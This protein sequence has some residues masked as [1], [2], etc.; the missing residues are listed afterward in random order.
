MNAFDLAGVS[1]PRPLTRWLPPVGG[2]LAA[3]AVALLACRLPTLHTVS[4]GELIGSAITCVLGVLL[5]SAITVWGICFLSR[6]SIAFDT[7]RLVLR[8]SLIALWIAPLALLIREK[9]P[10]AIVI[11]AVLVANFVRLV[12]FPQ[13]IGRSAVEEFSPQESNP[14]KS[15]NFDPNRN[16]FR[17]LESAPSVRQQAF[18][19]SAALCAE[20]GIA[21]AFAG[22]PFTSV[23]LVA[24]ATAVWTW[25]YAR[26][27]LPA[28]A[29]PYSSSRSSSRPLSQPLMIIALAIV[30]TAAALLPY[31]PQSF[32]G[33]FGVPSRS[34]ARRRSPQGEPGGQRSRER[35][36]EASMG[37]TTQ[38]DPG[39]VL[40]PDKLTHT[41]LVAPAPITANA[42][43]TG[44]PSADPLVIPFAGVYW[45]FRAP[46]V[47]PPRSSRQAHG[48]PELL[49]IRSTDRRP[50]SMEAHENLGSMIDL[51]CC[52]KIQVA[53]RN[54]D[55]YPETVSLELILINTA[56]PGKPSQSLG[57]MLVKSTRRWK[58]YDEPAPPASE[59]LNFVMPPKSSLRSFD[60]VRIV[61][62]IDAVRADAG[63]RI[64][65]DHLVLIPRGL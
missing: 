54:A 13:D 20:A 25:S 32:G 48:S 4:W 37:P 23:A 41:K 6:R 49:D 12:R 14:D 44:H 53:I 57:R 34:H 15:L 35:T 22:Y 7:R 9:S 62:R 1:A 19:G 31:L 56:V 52:S 63:P 5:A 2:L 43:L 29:R 55:R 36:L 58:L 60:E 30:I 38:G 28:G 47:H 26:I 16:P 50:L 51:N 33:G 64:A 65:I 61:F 40:L 10:W 3:A 21:A 11:T 18:G 59:T 46:D 39:I 8:T 27:A 45:F 17:L 24:A 42:P